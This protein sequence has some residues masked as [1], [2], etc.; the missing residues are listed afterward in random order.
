LPKRSPKKNLARQIEEV[1]K[2][3]PDVKTLKKKRGRRED[4]LALLFG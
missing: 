2:T 3:I 1:D 4:V